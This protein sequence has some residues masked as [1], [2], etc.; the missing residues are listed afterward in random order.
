MSF[1]TLLALTLIA[2]FVAIIFASVLSIH[3][4]TAYPGMTPKINLIRLSDRQNHQL[5]K[6]VR[7]LFAIAHIIVLWSVAEHVGIMLF[8][9]F[10]LDGMQIPTEVLTVEFMMVTLAGGVIC[11]HLAWLLHKRSTLTS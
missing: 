11:S 3:Y 6:T 9:H 10:D 5:H 8:E 1:E 7:L 4:I 2:A